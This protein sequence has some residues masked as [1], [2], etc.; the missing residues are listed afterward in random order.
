MKV[1]GQGAYGQVFVVGSSRHRRAYCLKRVP[2]REL[3]HRQREQVKQEVHLL[4]TLR[5]HPNIVWF[6]K[7]WCISFTLRYCSLGDLGAHIK[8][9]WEGG[10]P[11]RRL[12]DLA[13]DW[14]IQMCLALQALHSRRVL[15]RDMKTGNVF[16]LRPA[17]VGEGSLVLKLG[18]FG[19]SKMLGDQPANPMH[20]KVA[21]ASTMIGTPVYMSPEMYRGKPYGFEADIWGLG[22][23]LY[24]VLH[25]RYAFEA[26]SLQGLAL[27]IMQGRHGPV[28]CS[29][30]LR[31][32]IVSMLYDRPEGR[33][34][35]QAILARSIVRARIALT[36]AGV[37]SCIE[38]H[39][40]SRMAQEAYK[41]LLAQLGYMGLRWVVEPAPERC[42]PRVTTQGAGEDFPEVGGKRLKNLQGE[43]RV[44]PGATWG[45]HPG[46][47]SGAHEPVPHR[48][49]REVAGQG[50][51]DLTYLLQ[52]D[53]ISKE[54]LACPFEPVRQLPRPASAELSDRHRAN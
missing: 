21:L 43:L 2:L 7:V 22:C 39:I 35:L 6:H 28:T 24:E 36:L 41:T 27:K 48:S 31:E 10:K 26:D 49:D 14:L 53:H 3:S 8:C 20:S 52:Y 54:N 5:G 40:G 50:V 11:P 18:D 42:L 4:E 33:P 15:H 1:L 16:L 45:A 37:C 17:S 46:G 32:L 29:E 13:I 19:V 44:S 47:C 51:T 9:L 30:G 23:V 25:G 12:E 38:S 34:A